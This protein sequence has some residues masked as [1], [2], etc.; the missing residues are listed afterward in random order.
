VNTYRLTRLLS[1]PS[2]QTAPATRPVVSASPQ[3]QRPRKQRVLWDP[4]RA[5]AGCA[6]RGW[7]VFFVAGPDPVGPPVR[8]LLQQYRSFP[9]RAHEGPIRLSS[10]A[11]AATLRV[12]RSQRQSQTA[13]GSTMG[14]CGTEE[15]VSLTGCQLVPVAGVNGSFADGEKPLHN[16]ISPRDREQDQISWCGAPGSDRPLP[17]GAGEPG[18]ASSRQGLGPRQGARRCDSPVRN[19]WAFFEFR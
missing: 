15:T 6:G 19:Y 7:R 4:P 18:R 2:R 9:A 14:P 3:A 5:R 10:M 11:L 12:R 1:Q 16:Q 13:G 17:P 8:R